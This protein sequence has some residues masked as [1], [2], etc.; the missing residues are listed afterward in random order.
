MTDEELL[1]HKEENNLWDHIHSFLSVFKKMKEGKWNWTKN[2]KCK[3]VVLRVDMRDGGCI[4]SDRNGRR[5]SPKML[6][7]QCDEDK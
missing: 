3:Y 5:I 1:K 7:Y 2:A 6:A 4:I